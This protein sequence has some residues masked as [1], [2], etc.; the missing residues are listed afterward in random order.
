MPLVAVEEIVEQLKHLSLEELEPVE[1]LL[2]QKRLASQLRVSAEVARRKV[3]GFLLRRIGEML[4]AGAQAESCS[5]DGRAFWIV[6][7]WVATPDRGMTQA[8]GEMLV[9]ADT[10]EVVIDDHHLN[11]LRRTAREVLAR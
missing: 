2:R 8:I 11:D 5:R 7:V 3:N 9:D 1:E 6:P 10:G 4:C